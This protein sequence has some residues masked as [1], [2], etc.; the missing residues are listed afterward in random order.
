MRALVKVSPNDSGG[1]TLVEVLMAMLIMTVGLLGLLRSVSAAYE[2]TLRNRLREEAVA[3]A[4]EQMNNLITTL[5]CAAATTV[6]VIGGV[7][8]SF[9]VIKKAEPIGEESGSLRLK[10]VVHWGFKNQTSAHELYR[11]KKAE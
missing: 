4:E 5:D 6:R 9:T 11:F 10:V 3:V 8:K 7:D 2:H 1:F